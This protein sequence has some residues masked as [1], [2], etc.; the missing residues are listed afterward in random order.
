MHAHRRAF[1]ASVLASALILAACTTEGAPMPTTGAES[2]TPSSRP[3][4]RTTAPGP[5]GPT[6]APV[7]VPEAKWAA[8][9]ADLQA[10]DVS[11]APQLIS[12]ER[13]EFADGSLG[14]PAPGTSYTQAT[15][16][17]YRIVVRADDRTYDYRFGN[18][19]RP[20]LCER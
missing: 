13:V 6:G 19:D 20:R 8:I 4:F 17:G 3:P 9:V 11:G 2:S 15:V 16:D 18:G 1:A 7:A 12:S 10:R 5:I 14:C